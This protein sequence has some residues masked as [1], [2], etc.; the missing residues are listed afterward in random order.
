MRHLS[1]FAK[2][3]HQVGVPHSGS[4]NKEKTDVPL[5]NRQKTIWKA[6]IGKKAKKCVLLYGEAN[7]W[8]AYLHIQQRLPVDIPVVN[9]PVL[10]SS[11]AFM[12]NGLLKDFVFKKILISPKPHVYKSFEKKMLLAKWHP[13]IKKKP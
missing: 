1:V 3:L 2:D 12:L 9:I 6:T 8:S 4:Q 13:G 10:M 5:S 11:K 7:I